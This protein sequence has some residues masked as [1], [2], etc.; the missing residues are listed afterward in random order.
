MSGIAFELDTKVFADGTIAGADL[1][2]RIAHGEFWVL[3]APSGCGESTVLRLV[4]GLERVSRGTVRIGDQVVNATPPRDRQIA[5]VFETHALYP[6][7][8]VA[9]NMDFGLR[10]QLA[11]EEPRR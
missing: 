2:L 1:E 5:M 9:E 10:A 4:A 7:M 8:T 6:H 11:R 3:L